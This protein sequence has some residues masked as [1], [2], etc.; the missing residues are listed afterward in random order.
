MRGLA[1]LRSTLRVRHASHQVVVKEVPP[2]SV[3]E[4]AVEGTLK[5][6]GADKNGYF[7][8]AVPYTDVHHSRFQTYYSLEAVMRD[9]RL[10]QPVPK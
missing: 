4:K 10:P 2:Q 7:G 5:K 3:L 9:K 8:R 6:T 1:L